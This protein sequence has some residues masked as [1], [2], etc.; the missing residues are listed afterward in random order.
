MA[1]PWFR[2]YAEWLT[3]PKVQR[4]EEKHQR[5]LVAIF[6]LRCNGDVTLHDNDV[7]FML[8]ISDAEWQESKAIFIAENFINSDGEVL[9]WDKRQYISDTSAA[10]VAKHRAL[11]KPVTVTPCNVTVTPPEQIQN[12]TDTEQKQNKYMPPI[13]VE[14]LADWL[15]VRKAKRSGSVTET[16]FN[17][18]AREAALAN[19]T[20]EQAVQICCE[21]GWASFK[22]EW[23]AKPQVRGN[24]GVQEARLDTMRQIFG[25]KH[26]TNRTIIDITPSHAIESGGTRLPKTLDGVWQPDGI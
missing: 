12:R 4:L 23:Y 25:D 10:R 16:V 14:L 17:G 7:T 22:A 2:L 21:R 1:N 24:G 15:A 13:G 8:R 9:N 3:D 6:C 5:R 26:G 18:V 20:P 19:L 11:H